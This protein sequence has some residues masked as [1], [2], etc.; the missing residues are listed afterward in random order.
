MEKLTKSELHK[1]LTGVC[2]ALES[3]GYTDCCIRDDENSMWIDGANS[4]G[5]EFHLT[6]IPYKPDPP[7]I[8]GDMVPVLVCDSADSDYLKPRISTGEVDGVG[9]IITYIDLYDLNYWNNWYN[10]QTGEHSENFPIDRT[11]DKWLV[12]K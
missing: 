3:A 10:L 2:A 7:A 12:K 11:P 1:R 6:R 5:C 8:P 4:V 9:R